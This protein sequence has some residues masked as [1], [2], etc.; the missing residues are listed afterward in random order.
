MKAANQGHADAE[1]GVA[2]A[3]QYGNGVKIDYKEAVKWYERAADHYVNAI[4]H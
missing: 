2:E 1:Y 4:R 3:Y